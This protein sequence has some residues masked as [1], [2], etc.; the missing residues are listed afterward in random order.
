VV[1]EPNTP[2]ALAAKWEELLSNPTMLNK[3]S[4]QGRQAISEKFDINTLTDK[5]VAV[6][7]SLR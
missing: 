7:N 3:M 5:M 2:G 4:R 1:Y 6:Y